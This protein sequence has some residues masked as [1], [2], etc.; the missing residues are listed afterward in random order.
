MPLGD[1]DKTRRSYELEYAIK[2]CAFNLSWGVVDFVILL[3]DRNEHFSIIYETSML[4]LWD[5]LML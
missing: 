4:K 1:Y 2:R 5:S 3:L